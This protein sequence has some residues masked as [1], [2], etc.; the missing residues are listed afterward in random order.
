[1]T[2]PPCIKHGIRGIA[3]ARVVAVLDAG[4]RAAGVPLAGPIES[5]IDF[6]GQLWTTWRSDADRDTLARHIDLAWAQYEDGRGTLHLIRID[7]D[8][9]YQE[10]CMN[11]AASPSGKAGEG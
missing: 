9:D 2:T 10:D 3:D 6:D 7:D 8:Y 5:M 1:M 4:S 11:E